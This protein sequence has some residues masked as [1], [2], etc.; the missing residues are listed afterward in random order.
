MRVF[1]NGFLST[2]GIGL[3]SDLSTQVFV[4]EVTMSHLNDDRTFGELR[5]YFDDSSWDT[6][7]DGLIYTDP[8]FIQ[9]LKEWLVNTGFSYGALE[10]LQYSEQGM[11]GI[12]FVSFDVSTEFISE[13]LSKSESVVA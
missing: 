5:V 11:Q 7:T 3:W 10:G 6:D 1:I 4:R 12:N 9:E 8:L 2:S 13:W